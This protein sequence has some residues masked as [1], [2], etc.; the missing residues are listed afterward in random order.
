MEKA[1][2]PGQA[3]SDKIYF[4]TQLFCSIKRIFIFTPLKKCNSRNDPIT[5]I[6]DE[7]VYCVLLLFSRHFFYCQGRPYYRRRNVLFLS[8]TEWFGLSI[9]CYPEVIYAL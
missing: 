3:G 5:Y 7:K 8:G 9:Q 6:P 4:F 1:H 2:V